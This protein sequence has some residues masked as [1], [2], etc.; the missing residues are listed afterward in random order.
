MFDTTVFWALLLVTAALS[1]PFSGAR[2]GARPRAAL[3]I[4]AS[5]L[6]LHLVV[7]LGPGV[8]LLLGGLL[9]W[10]LLGI[11]LTRGLA[12][13]RPTLALALV[14]LPTAVT[15]I[16]GKQAVAQAIAPLRFFYFVGFSYFLVK[17]W[18][19]A[20][21]AHDGRVAKV[22]PLV[23]GAYF[24]AFPT[25]VAGPMPYYG[26]LERGLQE[27]APPRGE[28][29]L[30]TV[31]RL[32]VGLAKVK[33]L[34]PMLAPLSLTA[35]APPLRPL[36][37]VVACFAYSIVI[38]AD[39]SGYSDMA[40]ACGRLLGLEL[41]ENFQRPYLSA[42]VREFWQRWHISFSRVLTGYVF[43]PLSRALGERLGERRRAILIIGYLA[44]FLFCGYWHGPTLNFLLWGLYH[45]LGLIAYDL[46]RPWAQRRRRKKGKAPPPPPWRARLSHAA[47]VAGTF[48]FVSLGWSFFVLP[49]RTLLTLVPG[50]P[51]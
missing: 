41:P 50:G 8:L 7:G 19:L 4:L 9:A 18:T 21:D 3:L 12:Q 45:A 6:C 48:A 22:D 29:L 49:A 32:F 46:Y 17:A 11:H 20:K 28:A 15:W 23:A 26:E 33:L 24:L 38:W 35:V 40:I 27:G 25:Y 13:R 36:P 39:F 44:T 10:T 2:G 51:R 1:L 14:L 16:L 42:N 5:L 31:L 30:D 43:I 34:G 37:L 47:A